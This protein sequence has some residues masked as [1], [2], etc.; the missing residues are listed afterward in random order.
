MLLKKISEIEIDINEDELYV[1]DSL[2]EYNDADVL[3]YYDYEY[4]NELFDNEG[5]GYPGYYR[6]Y[7]IRKMFK[8]K[9]NYLC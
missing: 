1:K 8:K 5:Q 7:G 9:I 3:D 4:E 2:N 6:I